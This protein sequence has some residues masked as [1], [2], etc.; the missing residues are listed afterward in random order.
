MTHICRIVRPLTILGGQTIVEEGK[1]DNAMYFVVDGEVEVTCRG[2]RLGFLG[3]DS[4]FGELT[5]IEDG[6]GSETRTR[7]VRATVQTDLGFVVRDDLVAVS[8][9]W[10]ELQV[11]TCLP[12]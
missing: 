5:L 2:A 4:F 10:P 1:P 12:D 3:N 11:T 7:T 9:A 8:S 6:T